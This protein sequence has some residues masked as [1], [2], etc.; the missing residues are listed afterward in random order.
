MYIDK[1]YKQYNH[2]SRYNN[3]PYFYD[4]LDNKYIY[5]TTAYLK[6]DT[7]YVIHTVKQNDSLDSLAL[8]Y[9]NNPTYFWQLYFGKKRK[10]KKKTPNL[11][12]DRD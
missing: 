1:T 12:K 4:T 3:F 9:Y 11:L 8:Y 7:P 10:L 5:G 6:T 2:L